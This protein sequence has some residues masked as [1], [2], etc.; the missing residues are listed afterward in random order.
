[1]KIV[2]RLK[3]FVMLAW[4]LSSILFY[5]LSSSPVIADNQVLIGVIQYNAKGG[6]PHMY[7]KG[8]SSADIINKQVTLIAD[9]M[10]ENNPA[11]VQFVTLVQATDPVISDEFAQLDK[12]PIT[13]WNTVRGACE[14]GTSPNPFFEGTQ[15]A[16]SPEWELTPNSV[17]GMQNPLADS[18]T[19]SHCF[20]SGRPYNIA[21]F[22]NKKNNDLKVLLIVIHPPH[23]RLFS[24]SIDELEQCKKNYDEFDNFDADVRKVTGT[25]K[26]G[27]LTGINT[28]ISGDTNEL[29]NVG[30][31]DN[32]DCPDFK[33]DG[34]VYKYF[35][36]QFGDLS[37]STIKAKQC[38]KPGE[39]ENGTCCQNSSFSNYFDRVV[40]NRKV[41][42]PY[43]EIIDIAGYPLIPKAAPRNE[44]HKA[45]YAVVAFPAPK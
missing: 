35:F 4:L 24:G 43:E 7:P 20:S 32:Q 10:R 41:A 16:Y 36:P 40:V 14:G 30:V 15:I 27:D 8:W 17:S 37:V 45:V 5:V 31:P 3:S 39:T 25:A 38:F 1:M 26:N 12:N 22:Q 28:I 44:E 2:G 9:K 11:P 33:G 29:G 6:Q 19:S 13:G 42:D 34:N 21:Y 18:F 23:C